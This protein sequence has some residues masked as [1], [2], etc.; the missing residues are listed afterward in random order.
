MSSNFQALK[1]K[2]KMLK[3]AAEI[4][5]VNDVDLPKV[6]DRFL[7]EIEEMNHKLASE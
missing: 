1:N 3:K 5:R 7:R 4:L 2:E 6:V